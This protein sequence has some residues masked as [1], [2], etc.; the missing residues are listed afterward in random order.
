[1]STVISCLDINI[2]DMFVWRF[3]GWQVQA[4]WK[5][6]DVGV[7]A[8]TGSVFKRGR[9]RRHSY[10]SYVR[11]SYP[12]TL[13]LSTAIMLKSRARLLKS[14]SIRT[15]IRFHS[16][17][18]TMSLTRKMHRFLGHGRARTVFF[19]APVVLL[20]SRLLH[21][22]EIHIWQHN[23]FILAL[24]GICG[25]CLT[26]VAKLRILIWVNGTKNCATLANAVL[27]SVLRIK[28]ISTKR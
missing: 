4:H 17:Y 20:P 19:N 1:M 25:R 10:N 27:L 24:T 7:H 28:L 3:C 26:W 21:S 12:R 13:W 14:A 5:I 9:S 6:F 15:L 16:C 8:P 18:Q 23:H 22:C 11:F 2:A